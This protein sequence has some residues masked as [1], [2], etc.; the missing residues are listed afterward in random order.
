MT[1]TDVW[2]NESDGSVNERCCYIS[3]AAN[4]RR[5]EMHGQSRYYQEEGKSQKIQRRKT[6]KRGNKNID[7]A[8]LKDMQK[9]VKKQ[10]SIDDRGLKA[11][12]PKRAVASIE[13]WETSGLWEEILEEG[14]EKSKCAMEAVPLLHVPNTD[15]EGRKEPEPPPG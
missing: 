2:S 9:E 15:P 4:I 12:N 8:S 11:K 14:V 7:L 10:T 6:S 13:K 1:P 3:S 5:R